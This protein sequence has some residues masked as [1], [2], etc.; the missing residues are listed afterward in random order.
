MPPVKIETEDMQIKEELEVFFELE[1]LEE[2]KELID[3]A[4][5][6]GI[7]V[8]VTSPVQLLA[9]PVKKKKKGSMK[10][11][12]EAKRRDK[13]ILEW[14][15]E[16]TKREE[17][18]PLAQYRKPKGT[19]IMANALD[20][21][22]GDHLKAKEK[23]AAFIQAKSLEKHF[24]QTGYQKNLDRAKLIRKTRKPV[25]PSWLRIWLNAELKDKTAKADA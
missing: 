2:A 12:L 13:K 7:Q 19:G 6:V 24:R 5:S 21:V 11:K 10:S 8:A 22:M 9:V 17:P 18:D 25:D 1:E 16:P 23:K 4:W 14:A 15:H 3:L 20:E